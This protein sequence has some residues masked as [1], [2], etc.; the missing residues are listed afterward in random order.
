VP[1]KRGGPHNMLIIRITIWGMLNMGTAWT[2]RWRDLLCRRRKGGNHLVQ[3]RAS[4]E[5]EC[6]S[7]AVKRCAIICHLRPQN[8]ERQISPKAARSR[9]DASSE[10]QCRMAVAR[11]KFARATTPSDRQPIPSYGHPTSNSALSLALVSKADP[12]SC[13]PGPDGGLS[14]AP[15]PRNEDR[16][17]VPVGHGRTFSGPRDGGLSSSHARR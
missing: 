7:Q 12:W 13:W 8:A 17:R 16:C 14:L 6:S 5:E 3:P 10:G 15:R 11:C 2:L 4:T 9:G 1:F